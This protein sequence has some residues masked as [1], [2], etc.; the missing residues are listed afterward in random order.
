MQK[1]YREI[2][3]LAIRACILYRGFTYDVTTVIASRALSGLGTRGRRKGICSL[4][5]VAKV[6]PSSKAEDLKLEVPVQIKKGIKRE[7]DRK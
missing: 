3:C 4:K 6:T 5:E 2:V 1:P 7:K